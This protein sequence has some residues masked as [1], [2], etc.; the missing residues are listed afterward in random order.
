MRIRILHVHAEFL[1]AL[2]KEGRR[3]NISVTENPLPADARFVRVGHDHVG[4]LNLIIESATF[5]EVEDGEE[6]PVHPRVG[7]TK[8]APDAPAVLA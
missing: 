6:I 8:H 3:V 2:C 4:G 5:A 1:V 7:F